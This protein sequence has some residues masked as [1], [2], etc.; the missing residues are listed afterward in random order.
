MVLAQ[1]LLQRQPPDACLEACWPTE[2]SDKGYCLSALLACTAHGL[3]A[4]IVA[5]PT[6]E[7][8]RGQHKQLLLCRPLAHPQ[9]LQPISAQQR[10]VSQPG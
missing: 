8:C 9:H 1:E 6:L 4:A 3:S 2:C 5:D 10:S 7:V